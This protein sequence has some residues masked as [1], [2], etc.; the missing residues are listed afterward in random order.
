M[1]ND[2]HKFFKAR[3]YRVQPLS[4]QMFVGMTSM[5]LPQFYFEI[6]MY[7]VH[8]H[9]FPSKFIFHIRFASLKHSNIH[10]SAESQKYLTQ[11]R[12]LKIFNIVQAPRNIQHSAGSQKYSTKCRLIEIFTTVQALRNILY[13]AGSL[14]YSTQCWLLE[15]FTTI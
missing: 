13:S 6:P 15:V 2:K 12:F 3:V 1:T 10:T 7:T 8:I 14:K 4:C 9:K 5:M 11:C